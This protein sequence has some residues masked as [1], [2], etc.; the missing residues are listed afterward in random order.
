MYVEKSSRLK[1]LY[2]AKENRKRKKK[3]KKINGGSVS[4]EHDPNH[5]KSGLSMRFTLALLFHAV[6]CTLALRNVSQHAYSAS[7]IEIQWC[8]LN[9][10]LVP[11]PSESTSVTIPST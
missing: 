4:P 1:N 9:H 2:K 6:A 5:S 8:R 7:T 11:A 10:R 3:K